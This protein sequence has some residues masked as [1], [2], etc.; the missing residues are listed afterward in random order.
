MPLVKRLGHVAY[1]GTDYH[2]FS[3]SI[4]KKTVQ[5]TIEET[6]VKIVNEPSIPAH[7]D[8]TSRTD[9]GV[10]AQ[11]QVVTFF[12]PDYFD[13]HK[14]LLI[15]NQRLPGDIRFQS[16][17][18]ISDSFNLRDHVNAKIYQYLVSD[19]R[20]NP[21][22][23]RYAWTIHQLPDILL[24][25][26]FLDVMVGKHDFSS[27]AK[28]SYRYSSTICTIFRIVCYQKSLSEMIIEIEGD[29]FLY[30]MVRRI[31]GFSIFLAIKNKSPQST[32]EDLINQ[33]LHQTNMRAPASGL[34]L[35]KVIL[36]C[37]S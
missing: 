15:L 27:L 21:F 12:A 31:V 32:F 16:L 26:S 6:L 8:F 29:R 33:Y 25:K 13:N 18:N 37:D 34:T 5:Q 1:D 19:D 22:I 17:T 10:H 30:N 2:G 11:D 23:S 20:K 9:A 35:L 3:I 24:I 4:G 36:S 14:L 7:I 28:E